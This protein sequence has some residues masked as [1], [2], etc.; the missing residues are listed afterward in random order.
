MPLGTPRHKTRIVATVGPASEQP[1]VLREML[2]AGMNVARLNF[3]HGAPEDHRRLIAH[4]REASVHAGRRVAILGDLPGP[5]IRIGDLPQEPLQLS[6]GEIVVLSGRE[7]APGVIPVQFPK[8]AEALRPGDRLFVNDGFIELQVVAVEGDRVRCRVIV[9]GELR[10]RKGLNFPGI[11]LGVSAFTAQDHTWLR[12]AAEQGLDAVS[13]SFVARPED[14]QAVREAARALNYDPLII[15]KIE[16]A[17]ALDH[18]EAILDA[19]DGLMVARGD[20]GVE[21]PIERIAVVQKRIMRLANRAGKP[22]ITATQMLESMV[23]HLRPTRA[24]ATDVANAILDGTDCVML[25]EES[26]AGRHPVE[27]VRMLGRIAHAT[28]PHRDDCR[29]REEL[30]Q[31]RNLR[32]PV[33]T[34][35]LLALSIYHIIERMVPVAVFVPTSSGATARSVTRFR[36]PT[37]IVALSH[38]EKTCQELLFSYGVHPV[39]V[40][41]QLEDW[42]PYVR[43]WLAERDI[44]RGLALLMQGPSPA[45]PCANQRLELLDL[46]HQLPQCRP[47]EGARPEATAPRGEPKGG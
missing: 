8:L 6:R 47:A 30:Q 39:H 37:W 15:A 34:V 40:S 25:S 10:S 16:R 9:G 23:E 17:N 12:F 3:S 13:Q 5:K 21:I 42:S 41:Q 24:E 35:D 38:R 32:N 20:L 46:E 2:H 43:R 44:R 14:V 27:A 19:A 18:L 45:H 11:D 28:E 26:A 7:S 22:V 36:L 29:L 33:G 4:I 1:G 31:G